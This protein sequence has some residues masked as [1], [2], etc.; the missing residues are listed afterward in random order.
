MSYYAVYSGIVPGI[1]T[2]WNECQIQINHFPNAKYKKFNNLKDAMIFM[3]NGQINNDFN[4][5]KKKTSSK[6]IIVKE[7]KNSSIQTIGTSDKQDLYIYTDGSCLYNGKSNAKGGIGIHFSDDQFQDISE[8]YKPINLSDKPTNNKMELL[9]IL[10]SMKIV[11]KYVHLYHR[12]IIFTDSKYSID[13]LTK[14]IKAWIKND[15]KTKNN[16]PVSNKL[17]IQSIYNWLNNHPSVNFEHIN[18]HTGKT[19][20]HSK[21]NDIADKLAVSAANKIN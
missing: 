2:T 9:A 10:C 16:Q 12:I 4:S 7:N 19:D 18:S 20:R 21:G 14:Y 5:K 8:K 11:E 15:W 6:S 1:Y 17:L 3:E 13:C